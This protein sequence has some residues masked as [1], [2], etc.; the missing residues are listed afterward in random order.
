MSQL[1][2]DE[3]IP[4][5]AETKG[6]KN[7]LHSQIQG[8]SGPNLPKEIWAH[9]HS[10]L[11]MRDAAQVACVSQDFV[12]S[13]RCR[14]HLIFN[15]ETLGLNQSTCREDDIM[16]NFTDRVDNILKNHS[17]IGVK[18]L[19]FWFGIACNNKDLCYL[20]HLDNWLQIAVKPGIEELQLRLSTFNARYNFPC[21]LLSG[22]TASSL[23]SLY[24]GSCGFHPT[25][26][27]GCLRSLIKLELYGVCIEEEELKCLLSNTPSLEWLDVKFCY[28]ITSLRIPYLQQLSYLGVS[29]KKKHMVQSIENKAPNLSSFYFQD[30][31]S[32]LFLLGD[33]LLQIKKLHMACKNAALYALTELPSSMPSLETLTIHSHGEEA[34]TPMVVSKFLHLR[35]LSISTSGSAFDLWFVTNFLYAAPSLET[36]VVS[37]GGTIFA[38]PSGLKVMPKHHHEK[39]KSVQILGFSSAKCVVEFTHYILESAPLLKCL[40]LDTTFGVPRCSVPETSKC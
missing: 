15:T 39:L 23:R 32:V 13:W 10:L 34:N 7:S 26:T 11:P 37:V 29:C 27:S 3:P 35:F 6:S 14:P 21:S 1:Q 25:L 8:Y 4:S 17:G 18:K 9:I 5:R 28:P 19:K 30:E 31:I 38:D 40:T 33:T 22:G 24:L 20:D 36:L 16:R 12:R 2:G